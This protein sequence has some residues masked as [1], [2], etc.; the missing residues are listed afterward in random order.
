M[1]GSGLVSQEAS[2]RVRPC[3]LR[4]PGVVR[5]AAG[6]KARGAPQRRGS[7]RRRERAVR[8]ARIGRRTRPALRRALRRV[9][10][11]VDD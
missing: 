10:L 5:M 11:G 6:G 3:T 2:R 8:G 1:V 4:G 9:L 7:E